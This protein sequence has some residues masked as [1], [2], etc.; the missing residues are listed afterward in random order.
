MTKRLLIA[1]G[2]G[3]VILTLAIAGVVI[4]IVQDNEENNET[5]QP[6]ETQNLEQ[7][8]EDEESD[9][10]VSPETG[11]DVFNCEVNGEQ[12]DYTQNISID[13]PIPTETR[14]SGI[15]T[16]GS[17]IKLILRATT[18]GTYSASTDFGISYQPS[19]STFDY[20]KIYSSASGKPGKLEL[21][22]FSE[23]KITA[24][25]EGDVYNGNNEKL[26]LANCEIS[27]TRDN[28]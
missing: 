28:E 9:N 26:S 6:A 14:V 8:N 1:L 5:N 10:N 12:L 15:A 27:V 17:N 7:N 25:F 21:I 20:D 16:D 11:A 24:E 13:T 18:P 3:I 2:I 23:S 19:M 4:L 22:E